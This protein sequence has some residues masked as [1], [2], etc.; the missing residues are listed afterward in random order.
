MESERFN[1]TSHDLALVQDWLDAKGYSGE[2]LTVM[3]AMDL[4][5]ELRKE[6]KQLKDQVT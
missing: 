3:D 4:I 5:A 1:N 2:A 6:I